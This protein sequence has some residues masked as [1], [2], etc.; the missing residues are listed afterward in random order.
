[1]IEDKQREYRER[2]LA[3]IERNKKIQKEKSKKRYNED[4]DL[5]ELK[6]VLKLEEFKKQNPN[7]KLVTRLVYKNGEWKRIEICQLEE[8]NIIIQEKKANKEKW[9]RINNWCNKLSKANIERKPKRYHKPPQDLSVH[10]HSKCKVPT[11]AKR[12][13]ERR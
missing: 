10:T 8:D 12:K 5:K 1:M 7:K 9:D 13:G 6:R 11:F 3:E 4:K 2:V